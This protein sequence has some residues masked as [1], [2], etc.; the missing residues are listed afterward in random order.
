MSESFN[1][2]FTGTQGKLHV[3]LC[4]SHS[5]E[6]KQASTKCPAAPA[7]VQ[8]NFHVILQYLNSV[9]CHRFYF[10]RFFLLKYET[11]LRENE[12]KLVNTRF[13]IPLG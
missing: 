1:V 7:G 2:Y 6:N 13:V 10:W 4:K 5:I 12:F 11:K 8:S 9:L 3:I